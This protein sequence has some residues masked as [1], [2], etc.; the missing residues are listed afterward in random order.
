MDSSQRRI[1]AL[2][3]YAIAL[4]LFVFFFGRPFWDW[5]TWD[6]KKGTFDFGIL[7]VTT[8]PSFPSDARAIVVGL[9]LPI[10]LAATG[11]VIEKS[12]PS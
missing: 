3:A 4:I 8:R 2:A 1:V 9:I 6:P 11:R 5:M 7:K 12:R 10:V